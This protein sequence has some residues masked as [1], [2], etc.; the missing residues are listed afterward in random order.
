MGQTITAKVLEKD[1]PIAATF[2]TW[3]KQLFLTT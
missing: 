2:T 3:L 1:A